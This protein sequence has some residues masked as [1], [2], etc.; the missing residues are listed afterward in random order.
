M[1]KLN[2]CS[3]ELENGAE[4]CRLHCG[5]FNFKSCIEGWFDIRVEES[6]KHQYLT[7]DKYCIDNQMKMT[8]KL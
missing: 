4:V 3:D 2:I 7:T 8:K 1:L 5:H 6:D